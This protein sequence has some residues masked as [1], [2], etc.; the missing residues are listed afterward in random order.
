MTIAIPQISF[1]LSSARNM[2]TPRIVVFASLQNREPFCHRFEFP[3]FEESDDLET[4]DR[5]TSQ[6]K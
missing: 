3:E 4:K 1:F 2:L 6:R 5:I